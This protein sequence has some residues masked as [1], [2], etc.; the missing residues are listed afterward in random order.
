MYEHDTPLQGPPSPFVTCAPPRRPIIIDKLIAFGNGVLDK[1][2]DS[3][4]GGFRGE[5]KSFTKVSL[6]MLTQ[7]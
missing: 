7:T 6:Q 5:L 3:S 2:Q 1:P 4:K